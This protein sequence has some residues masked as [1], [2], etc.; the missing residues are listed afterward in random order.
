MLQKLNAKWDKEIVD[1]VRLIVRSENSNPEKLR[2]LAA[3]VQGQGL[4]AP[5][6]VKP[7]P[8]IAKEDIRVVCWMAISN[9]RADH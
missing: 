1:A 3:Y 2:N 9:T 7:L 4:R 5:A 8:V 6:P